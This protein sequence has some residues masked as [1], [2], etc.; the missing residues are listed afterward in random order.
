FLISFGVVWLLVAGDLV[1]FNRD[2]AGFKFG[3]SFVS[4]QEAS[5]RVDESCSWRLCSGLFGLWQQSGL[6]MADS[7]CIVIFG[8]P[9]SLGGTKLGL[10]SSFLKWS[11][12]DVR[13]LLVF[14]LGCNRKG[15]SLHRFTTNSTIMERSTQFQQAQQQ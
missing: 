11:G 13:L 3:S 15:A 9:C 12:F 10:A 8:Q 6:G 4:V 1:L 7:L 2:D 14:F 5:S